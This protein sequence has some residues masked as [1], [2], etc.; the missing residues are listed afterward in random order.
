M[1]SPTPSLF[2]GLIILSP[3]LFV[4]MPVQEPRHQ[5]HEQEHEES[6]LE[7]SM[8][9]LKSGFKSLRR[10]LPVP[11]A[12]AQTLNTLHAMQSAALEC[13]PFC[14]NPPETFSN[15]EALLWNLQYRRSMLQVCSELCELELAVIEGRQEDAQTLFRSLGSIKKKGHRTYKEDDE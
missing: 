6:L 14:P 13:L 11:E 10:S 4:Y 9:S 2:S 7:E 5:E 8:E 3:L 12:Q 15:E 1:K